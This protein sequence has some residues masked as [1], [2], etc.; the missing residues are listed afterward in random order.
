MHVLGLIGTEGNAIISL[1]FNSIPR[2]RFVDHDCK[3]ANFHFVKI[4]P[5]FRKS[6]E[7]DQSPVSFT[8][9]GQDTSSCNI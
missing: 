7:R 8:L 9:G 4:A 6:I 2:K 5:K 1:K 3:L